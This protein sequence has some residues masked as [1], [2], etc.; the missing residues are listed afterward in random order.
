VLSD[1]SRALR[2]FVEGEVMSRKQRRGVR[3]AIVMMRCR[4]RPRRIV[5]VQGCC[6]EQG[7]RWM[8]VWRRPRVADVTKGAIRDP[9]IKRGAMMRPGDS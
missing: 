3:A 7:D 6:D 9:P 4:P 1:K 5:E 2:E 8:L